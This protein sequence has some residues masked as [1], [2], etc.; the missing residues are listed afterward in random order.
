MQVRPHE[1]VCGQ[2]VLR[3]PY[4]SHSRGEV[5]GG[6]KRA[7]AQL[8]R[9]RESPLHAILR[10]QPPGEGETLT[11]LQLPCSF[12]PRRYSI[13]PA[14]WFFSKARYI[15][16]SNAESC[17]RNRARAKNNIAQSSSSLVCLWLNFFKLPL[18][19]TMIE[20]MYMN[21]SLTSENY[22]IEDRF[23]TWDILINRACVRNSITS[24]FFSFLI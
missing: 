9:G 10:V 19:Q 4:H 21:S 15:F 23:Y 11:P 1:P 2:S 6:I 8:P 17:T 13:Q 18:W 20:S 5:I 3:M 16:W 12:E 7:D 22:L 24:K 14:S